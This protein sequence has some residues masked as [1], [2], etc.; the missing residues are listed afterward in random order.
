M[1]QPE[2][3]QFAPRGGS[4]PFRFQPYERDVSVPQLSMP[5]ASSVDDIGQV[6]QQHF[7][8]PTPISNTVSSKT[9]SP[10]KFQMPSQHASR[11]QPYSYPR[12]I[13]Q[14]LP[15]DSLDASFSQLSPEKHL[16]PSS[17]ALSGL[18][19]PPP[20]TP[21]FRASQFSSQLSTDNIS[22]SQQAKSPPP[23]HSHEFA[24]F[25]SQ[26]NAL[27]IGQEIAKAQLKAYRSQDFRE[28]LLRRG[29]SVDDFCRDRYY[30]NLNASHRSGNVDQR[31]R[32]L[33]DVAIW[34][35]GKEVLIDNKFVQ[36]PILRSYWENI[37]QEEPSF[38]DMPPTYHPDELTALVRIR[39]LAKQVQDV[40]RVSN[41][42]T[43]WSEFMDIGRRIELRNL[44]EQ[45]L[46]CFKEEHGDKYIRIQRM[47][48]MIV[49][50]LTDQNLRSL[51][52]YTTSAQQRARITSIDFMTK[53]VKEQLT[54]RPLQLAMS[55]ESNINSLSTLSRPPDLHKSTTIKAQLQRILKT[56]STNTAITSSKGPC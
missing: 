24:S 23:P 3:A 46:H 38:C 48:W 10:Q 33:K 47:L 1:F 20:I 28:G 50:E 18:N 36:K 6:V 32:D 42:Y 53:D 5:A 56:S 22:G 19:S 41:A 35:H 26:Q 2:L 17:P 55:H 30:E 9:I 45:Y 40:P 29:M 52:P 7:K 27:L 8:M 16:S 44:L 51:S 43:R 37:R 54:F 31:T 12:T 13:S 34:L 4:A 14:P 11:F 49:N 21:K 25:I 39:K 15:S